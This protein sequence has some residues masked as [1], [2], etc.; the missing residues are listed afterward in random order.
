MIKKADGSKTAGLL[1]TYLDDE[2]DNLNEITTAKLSHFFSVVYG[3][4][5]GSNADKCLSGLERTRKA[6]LERVQEVVFTYR[7]VMG[8]LRRGEKILTSIKTD[9]EKKGRSA[10]CDAAVL[11]SSLFAGM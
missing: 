10:R 4:D 9:M 3:A 7:D 8:S 6:V 5:Y 1:L 11:R 2:L